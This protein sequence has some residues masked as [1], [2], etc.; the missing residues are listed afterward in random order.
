MPQMGRYHTRCPLRGPHPC[1]SSRPPPSRPRPDR[2][3]RFYV[4]AGSGRKRH[5]QSGPREAARSRHRHTPAGTV[6]PCPPRDRLRRASAAVGLSPLSRRRPTRHPRKNPPAC[7]PP[8][9]VRC[10]APCIEI[11]P[12]AFRPPAGG[13]PVAHA[14]ARGSRAE[15]CLH[16]MERGRAPYPLVARAISAA[17]FP[18]HA[19]TG[20][21]QPQ[22]CIPTV[23]PAKSPAGHSARRPCGPPQA[24]PH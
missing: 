18:R 16:E 8:N 6:T 19:S 20:N 24:C 15:E 10:R 13:G 3:C 11:P 12:W 17:A 4:L 5:E 23:V 7:R 2:S 1:S 14:A 22:S 9:G 21:I